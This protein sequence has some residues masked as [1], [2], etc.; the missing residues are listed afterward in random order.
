MLLPFTG[1][2][3]GGRAPG[4]DPAGN[5]RRLHETTTTNDHRARARPPGQLLRLEDAPPGRGVD[6]RPGAGASRADA[7]P[8]TG[9]GGGGT[10]VGGGGTGGEVDAAVNGA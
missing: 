5:R 1:G 10:I 3:Q 2:T 8:P 7:A 9:T 4:D 6:A